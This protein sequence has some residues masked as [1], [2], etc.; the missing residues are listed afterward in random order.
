MEGLDRLRIALE[1]LSKRRIDAAIATALTRTVVRVRAE[2]V[3][4][5]PTVFDRPTPYTVRQLRY[6]AATASNLNAAVGFDIAAVTDIGGRVIAYR[7]LGPNERTADT[8][9]RPNIEGGPRRY[10]GL[11]VALRSIGALPV[12]WF[13]VPGDGATRDAF[14]NV[15][16]G[17]VVQILSQLRTNRLAGYSSNMSFDARKQINAQRKAGGRFF[18]I[19]PNSKVPPGIYQR[20]FIGNNITPIFIFVKNARYRR[21]YD[22]TRTAMRHATMILPKEIDKVISERLQAMKT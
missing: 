3:K 11:E 21:R 6:I 17:Q 7:Q 19:Q 9:I 15:P 4:A 13:A 5:L 10:K 14:G 16:R 20:E 2:M 8:Y 12:G 22:F 1:Q 18:V